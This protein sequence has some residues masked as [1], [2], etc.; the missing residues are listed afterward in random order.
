MLER[1]G[2]NQSHSHWV[3]ACAGMTSGKVLFS[4][5]FGCSRKT[6]SQLFDV[7]AEC[8]AEGNVSRTLGF[9]TH[10]ERTKKP[11]ARATDFALDAEA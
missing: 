5:G 2:D 11:T 9:F 1:S 4:P 7:C 8:F 10:P 6:I 3:P